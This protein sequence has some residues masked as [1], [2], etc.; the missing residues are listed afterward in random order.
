MI[1]QLP[2]CEFHGCDGAAQYKIPHQTRGDIPAC[3][4]H[5]VM[6]KWNLDHGKPFASLT[7]MIERA[8]MEQKRCDKLVKAGHPDPRDFMYDRVRDQLWAEVYGN[9]SRPKF[10]SGARR[11][12]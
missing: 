9:D 3:E 6:L 8:T 10:V 5:A 4:Y 11:A 12:N 1:L 7:D 2:A